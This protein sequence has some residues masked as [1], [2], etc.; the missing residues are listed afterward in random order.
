MTNAENI[1]YIFDEEKKD[2][3]R[4]LSC[5]YE[6]EYPNT[7]IAVGNYATRVIYTKI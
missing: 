1:V 6:N 3:E 2:F 7:A 5:P 4:V